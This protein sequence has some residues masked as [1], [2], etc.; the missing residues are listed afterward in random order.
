MKRIIFYVFSFSVT[1]LLVAQINEFKITASDGESGDW[2]GKSVS[3]SGDYAIVGAYGDDVNGTISG[4]AYIFKRDNGN[5]VEHQKLIAS[6]GE[7]GDKFG[8]SV[9]ISNNF[10]IIGASGD[11]D[12]GGSAYVFIRNDTIWNE[13]AKLIPD[14]SDPDDGFGYSVSITGEYAIIGALWDE[15]N[16]E[17]SGS[18]YIFKREN[19][20]WYQQIKILPSDGNID[21]YFGKSV[22]ISGNHSII[23][24]SG[25]DDNGDE[26]GSAYIYYRNGL[27]WYQQEK[28]TPLDGYSWD[29]F[30]YSVSIS[31]DFVIIGSKWADFYENCSGAAYIF[32]REYEDWIQQTILFDS[33]SNEGDVLGWSTAIS[34]DYAII[35][36][37]G[38]DDNGEDSGSVYI[39]ERDNQGWNL[40]VQ[41]IAFDGSTLDCFGKSVS[42]SDTFAI[43]G[44]YNDDDNGENSGSAY[45]YDF[46]NLTS[47]DDK[48]IPS[49]KYNLSNYPNPFNPETTISFTVTQKRNL[50]LSIYNIKGKIVKTL[51]NGNINC[52]EHQIIWNG[53]NEKNESV[54]SGIYLYKFEA[55]DFV[56]TKKMILLK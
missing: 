5:W 48:I 25:D 28:I 1:T 40:V 2:F 39:F 33:E 46:S 52:G 27:N 30:G 20:S 17:N 26:S 22:S 32:N 56:I 41:I 18:A 53:N 12:S 14:D 54:S 55:D 29:L 51:Y 3:I 13:Q 6:D 37:P 36:A 47:I 8:R 50:N 35:G 45:I 49:R 15:D 7:P 16:G 24:A 38:V 4:S 9:G 31:G 19:T 34:G 42:I 21:D 43:V 23:G 11:N 44:A 10:L